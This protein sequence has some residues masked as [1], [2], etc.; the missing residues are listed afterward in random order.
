MTGLLPL[1]LLVAVAGAATLLL[2]QGGRRGYGWVTGSEFALAGLALGPLGVD[3]LSLDLLD[4]AQLPIAL[5]ASWVGLGLGLRL[6]KSA[7]AKLSATHL[8]ASQLEP[9]VALFVL[10][11][12]LEAA[13]RVG[14][15]HL[16]STTSW[17]LA[18]A[19]AATTRS[20]MD[21]ARARHG[22]RG[23][24]TDSL[25][26]LC[27]FDDV[28]PLL[29]LAV[30]FALAPPHQTRLDQAWQ[31]LAAMIFLSLGL[32][33]VV[34][35]VVGRRRFRP[36]L[37]WL[38]LFGVAV[39]GTGLALELAL[40]PVACLFLCGAAVARVTRHA[41]RLEEVTRKTQRPVIQVLLLLGGASVTGG[42]PALAAGAAFA[43]LR[44]AAKIVAGATVAPLTEPGEASLGLG[45]LGGGGVLFA[46]AFS[47]SRAWPVEVAAP[48][49]AGAAAMVILG[50]AVGPHA[51]RSLLRRA[52]ELQSPQAAR[53]AEARP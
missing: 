2:E 3:L 39:L 14:L 40:L 4:R 5:G 23:P 52:G 50:D 47:A 18:A 46:A 21:W 11:L 1:V 53:P 9:L 28:P 17:A 43:L 31:R 12:L 38:A 42:G 41:D 20:M 26:A 51:L 6:R 45:M 29:A 33:A 16:S 7:L 10:R 27:T 8:L 32:A 22:A 36:Q 15:L 35:L 19:G 24:V 44:W 49:L 48:L 37:A 13:A 30:L 25:R 34:L